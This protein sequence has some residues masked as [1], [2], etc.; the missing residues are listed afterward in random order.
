MTMAEH[1]SPTNMSSSLE[2]GEG[3]SNAKSL[4]RSTANTA[5]TR[6]D[7]PLSI[8]QGTGGRPSTSLAAS[9]SSAS[10]SSDSDNNR[11]RAARRGNESRGEDSGGSDAGTSTTSEGGGPL[12]RPRR[13]ELSNLAVAEDIVARTDG[14]R[15]AHRNSDAEGEP[16]DVDQQESHHVRRQVRI[17][18]ESAFRPREREWH[19]LS[20]VADEILEGI[21]DDEDDEEDEEEGGNSHQI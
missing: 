20:L 17:P 3:D 5:T 9:S 15:N 6:P 12:L 7:P 19:Y 2:G 10:I 11:R 14:S 4:E 13:R 21:D 8:G 1:S 18:S 16:E